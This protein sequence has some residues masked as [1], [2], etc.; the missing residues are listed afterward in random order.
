MQLG[1]YKF[2]FINHSFN[3]LLSP[4]QPAGCVPMTALYLLLWKNMLPHFSNS[5]FGATEPNNAPYT[6]TGERT[7]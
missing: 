4:P 2:N 3:L 5:A 1:F 6:G 7:E